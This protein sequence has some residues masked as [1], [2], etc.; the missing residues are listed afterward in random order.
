[1]IQITLKLVL[2]Q[3][4]LL[5]ELIGPLE[6]RGQHRPTREV[7]LLLSPGRFCSEGE[8]VTSSLSSFLFSLPMFFSVELRAESQAQ[9]L[10]SSSGCFSLK[11]CHMFPW[12]S[13][14]G[15]HWIRSRQW[16]RPLQKKRG[17]HLPPK[18]WGVPRPKPHS[19][20]RVN[21]TRLGAAYLK[22]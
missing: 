3:E 21:F 18:G 10:R 15:Q 13:E 2:N 19:W 5:C 6:W 1:M 17:K 20:L 14:G 22:S 7:T 12:D 4:H 16:S 9:R 11:C 8:K